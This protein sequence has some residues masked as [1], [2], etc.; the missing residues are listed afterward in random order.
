MAAFSV[1]RRRLAPHAAL[2]RLNMPEWPTPSRRAAALARELAA[3]A[4]T[5]G[6][7]DVELDAAPAGGAEAPVRLRRSEVGAFAIAAD[8]ELAAYLRCVVTGA[9]WGEARP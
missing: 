8:A 3:A 9:L 5:P 1:E 4:R 7:G 6:A 2:R